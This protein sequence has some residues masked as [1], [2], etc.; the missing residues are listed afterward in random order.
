MIICSVKITCQNWHPLFTKKTNPPKK[1]VYGATYSCVYLLWYIVMVDP[2]MY[3]SQL[4]L[5]A[6]SEPRLHGLQEE[7]LLPVL[8]QNLCLVP[9]HKYT[10]IK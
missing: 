9:V 8:L 5:L 4:L 7:Q 1:H 10:H 6:W 3:L 2:G